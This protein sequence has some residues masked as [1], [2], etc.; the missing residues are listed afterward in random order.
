MIL[1]GAG[2]FLLAIAAY[3]ILLVSDGDKLRKQVWE[4]RIQHNEQTQEV[5][6]GI[7]KLDYSI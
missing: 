3:L 5:E 1:I 4:R 6:D 2:V 7:I